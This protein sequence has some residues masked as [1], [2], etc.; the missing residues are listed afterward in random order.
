M[1]FKPEAHPPD[2]VARVGLLCWIFAFGAIAL[3]NC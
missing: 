3:E 2:W 1:T